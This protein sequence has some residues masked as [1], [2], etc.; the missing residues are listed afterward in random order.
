M[1]NDST[2][3][4]RLMTISDQNMN[5]KK[6]LPPDKTY[7]VVVDVIID[8]EVVVEPVPVTPPAEVT[9]LALLAL[10]PFPEVVVTPGPDVTELPVPVCVA[11]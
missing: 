9:P 5:L 8:E 1:V 11:D 4:H 3:L 7:G 10:F 6:D 2:S